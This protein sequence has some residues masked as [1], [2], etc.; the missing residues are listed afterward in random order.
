MR[1]Q[2]LMEREKKEYISRYQ[3]NSSSRNIYKDRNLKDSHHMI[4]KMAAVVIQ[5]QV[6]NNKKHNRWSQTFKN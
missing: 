6:Y 2:I 3:I 5:K 4:V 1:M